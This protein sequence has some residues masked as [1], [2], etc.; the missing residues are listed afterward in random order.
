MSITTYLN[1]IG[2]SNFDEG[3]CLQVPQQIEDLYYLTNTKSK[4]NVM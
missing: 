3:F 1:K 2:F 4:I